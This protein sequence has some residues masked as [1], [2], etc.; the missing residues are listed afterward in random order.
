MVLLICLK[1]MSHCATYFHSITFRG[2]R[3]RA[4]ITFQTTWHQRLLQCDTWVSD[5][6]GSLAAPRQE[7]ANALDG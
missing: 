7:G 5:P 1:I 2:V 4:G 3:G 6:L